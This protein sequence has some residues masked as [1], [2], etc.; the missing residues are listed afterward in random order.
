MINFLKLPQDTQLAAVRIVADKYKVNDAIIEKDFWVVFV[1]YILF[2]ESKYSSSLIFKGG[3]SL[4]KAYNVIQRFSEDIDLVLD[5]CVLG[6]E[7]DEPWLERSKTAQKKFNKEVNNRAAIWI[8]DFLLP[9][10]QN[11]LKKLNVFDIDLKISVFDSQTVQIYY[12][13]NHIED[14][15]LQEIRLEIGPLA[16][17]TPID[18]KV[19]TSYVA[20]ALP[21]LFDNPSVMVPTVQAKRTFWEKVTILHKEANR[22]TS[23][24]PLRYSRHYYD[25]FRMG[26][27]E[28]RDHALND[29]ELL[30]KVIKF[31]E[32]FYSDNTAKYHQIM[33]GNL[34]LIP[35]KKQLKVLQNDYK[36]MKNMMFADY[37]EWDIIMKTLKELECE[38]NLKCIKHK[39]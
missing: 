30:E 32:K 12:P 39:K 6:Y 33:E 23:K 9:D 8:K 36:R 21:Q 3:T 26:I 19:I 11:C 17:W 34:V 13:N 10:I 18:N 20:E 2:S 25:V 16:A 35:N 5:W 31:K 15:L 24:T 29:I 22:I 1:L 28:I 27:E 37:P 14:I 7:R 38:I 4:S